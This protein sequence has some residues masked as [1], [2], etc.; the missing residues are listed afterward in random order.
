M[1][2]LR[3]AGILGHVCDNDDLGFADKT[4]MD[5]ASQREGEN[6]ELDTS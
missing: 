2:R 5:H 3:D 4:D 1:L 6:R